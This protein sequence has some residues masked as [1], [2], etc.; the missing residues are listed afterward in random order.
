[1]IAII[2]QDDS[3]EKHAFVR[4]GFLPGRLY[5][6]RVFRYAGS[7]LWRKHEAQRQF[8]TRLRRAVFLPTLLDIFFFYH[9]EKEKGTENAEI[10]F[11]LINTLWLFVSSVLKMFSSMLP[12]TPGQ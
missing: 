7:Q 10:K 4:R 5:P 8:R 3:Y 11:L 12:A 2:V 6:G 1:M 9:S